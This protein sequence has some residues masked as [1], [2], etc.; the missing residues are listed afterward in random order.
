MSIEGHVEAGFEGVAEVFRENFAERGEIGAAFAAYQGERRLVDLWGGIADGGSATPWREDTLQLIFSG[1]KGLVAICLLML[2]DRGQIALDDPVCKHWPE[3]AAGG[4]QEISVADVVS[5]H[6]RLPGIRKPLREI[7]LTN[8]VLIARLLA[9][10]APETDPR[11]QFA[12]HSLTY[13][14]LCGE[15]IRRVDGRSVGRFFAE[16]IASPLR[17][18]LWIGL[19]EAY[20]P[21]VSTLLYGPDWSW[22]ATYAKGDLADDPLL[23]SLRNPPVFAEGRIPWNTRA[24]HAAEIPAVNAIGTARSIAR[25]YS[26]LACGGEL[27]GV[28]LMRPD[29]I[30]LGRAELSRFTDRFNDIEFAFAAGFELQIKHKELG[31]PQNAFGHG[32]AGGSI[33]AAWPDQQIGVS[34]GMNELRNGYPAADPRPQ[35]LLRALY[36]AL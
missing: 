22:S 27:D 32:G 29:T 7:D 20:E 17:L 11:A 25:L 31:P 8:D 6:A 19:P 28:R 12:Y 15:L 26:C 18:E 3:F 10:Q 23:A 1:T 24:F 5:H 2:L 30:E 14:W 33:H 13:G 9:E 35:A 16:E 34:Y 36:D 4:K 21:R